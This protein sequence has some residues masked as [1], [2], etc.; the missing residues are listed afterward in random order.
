MVGT[1]GTILTGGFLDRLCYNIGEGWVFPQLPKAD[2]EPLDMW[3]D[4]ILTGAD[5]P[6]GID[7]AVALSATMELAYKNIIKEEG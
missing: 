4:G 1:K 2:P 7:D 3:I 6:Y 5:I